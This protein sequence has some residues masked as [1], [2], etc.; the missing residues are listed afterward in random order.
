MTIVARVNVPGDGDGDDGDDDDGVHIDILML[1][2]QSDLFHRYR[3]MSLELS[4]T[5]N[6]LSHV[7]AGATYKI[8]RDDKSAK[9]SASMVVRRLSFIRLFQ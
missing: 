7:V 3:G 5:R 2:A 9:A 8:V 1:G 6:Y 4:I